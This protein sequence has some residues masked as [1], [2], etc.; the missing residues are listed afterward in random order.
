[1]SLNVTVFGRMRLQ[2]VGCALGIHA[3]LTD[4]RRGAGGYEN[5][6]GHPNDALSPLREAQ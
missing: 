3:P 1:M 2:F 5:R 6:P 4:D